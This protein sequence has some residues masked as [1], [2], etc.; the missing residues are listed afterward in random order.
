MVAVLDVADTVV[1]T[2]GAVLRNKKCEVFKLRTFCL[3]LLMSMIICRISQ[4]GPVNSQFLKSIKSL[5]YSVL[6]L[7]HLVLCCKVSRI[8]MANLAI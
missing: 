5:V 3:G 4:H 6:C 2:G 7:I 1:I 8:V